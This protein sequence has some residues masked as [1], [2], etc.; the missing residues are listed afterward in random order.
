MYSEETKSSSLAKFLSIYDYVFLDTCSLMEDSF[1][2]FMDNLTASHEYWKDGLHVIVLGEC[3]EELKKHSASK[4]NQEARIEAKRAL[5]ILHHDKWFHK[6]LEVT[7]S[8]TNYG[9]ADNAIYTAVSSL[10]IQNKVLIVTQDKTLATDLKKLNSLDSQRGRY[11][12]VY[13]LNQQGDLEEN[14]GEN[15]VYQARNYSSAP[16]RESNTN[17]H[18]FHLGALHHTRTERPEKKEELETET[19]EVPDSPIVSADKRLMAN[20]NNPNYPVDKKLSDVSAQIAAIDALSSSE[21]EKL[22]LA[23][24]YDELLQEK[25]RLSGQPAPA[26]VTHSAAPL[27]PRKTPE[28]LKVGDKLPE[29]VKAAPAPAP[30]PSTSSAPA[31][32]SKPLETKPA[33]TPHAQHLWFEYGKSVQE[34]LSKT[35]AHYGIIFRDRSVPYVALV[36]GPYDL[37]SQDLDTAARSLGLIKPGEKKD[38][39]LGN[40]LAHVEKTD[41]EYKATIEIP[42]KAEPKIEN[43][44]QKPV[45]SSSKPIEE[46]P[47]Q[48]RAETSAPAPVTKGSEEKKPR[49]RTPAEK[50]LKKAEAKKAA[51][52][53]ASTGVTAQDLNTA[54]PAGATLVVGVPTNEG[55][56]GYIERQIRRDDQTTLATAANPNRP[57]RNPSS[58]SAQKP[59]QKPAPKTE[60]TPK[61]LAKGTKPLAHDVPPADKAA[62]VKED[63]NLNAKINNP[64]Y[65]VNQKIADLQAQKGKLAALKS[66]EQKDLYWTTANINAKIN[67]LKPK[68]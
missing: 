34:A 65:P 9:F 62:I 68:K 67:E 55:K 32:I 54:V 50:P 24:T 10:R 15:G 33:P 18:H 61:I 27:P 53:N 35:G 41:S 6:I 57:H 45:S 63:K 60:R 25:V 2:V 4:D 23:Y 5:K 49:R 16:R 59:A 14:P 40:L 12:L 66:A 11:V 19:V 58:K 29:M 46:K 20:L 8:N 43:P 56:K 51:S 37:T 31:P 52:A 36:H 48:S 22:S 64:N 3:V 44:Q 21:K 30:T 1:P 26:P 7:K 39:A 47:V 17:D 42:A 13:R 28:P 38:V